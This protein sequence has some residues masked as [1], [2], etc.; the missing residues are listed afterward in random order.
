[1]KL[2][3]IRKIGQITILVSNDFL[4]SAYRL[5]RHITEEFALI[6]SIYGDFLT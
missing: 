5:L 6:N 3:K 4:N 2:K 1:M